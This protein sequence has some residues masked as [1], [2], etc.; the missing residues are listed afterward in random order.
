MHG[1]LHERAVLLAANVGSLQTD[2]FLFPTFLIH[3]I[4][5][6]DICPKRGVGCIEENSLSLG[7]YPSG[8]GEKHF[9]GNK[10]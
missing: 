9:R 5:W 7:T 1:P 3:I 8:W 4:V 6:K 2:D 10:A